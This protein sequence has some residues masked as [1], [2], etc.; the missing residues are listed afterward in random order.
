MILVFVVAFVTILVAPAIT[1]GVFYLN[2]K[3]IIIE[4]C[5][6]KDKPELNCNG[7]CYLNKELNNY[8]TLN[9]D[10][11]QSEQQLYIFTPN[12]V[13]TNSP[14]DFNL[15]ELFLAS[16]HFSYEN[17][18]SFLYASDLLEPPKI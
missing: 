9:T 10:K 6:N 17:F 18:Y 16:H 12:F 13:Q 11:E 5:I 3:T 1:I 2:Q 14:F 8:K 4:K 15:K 7:H